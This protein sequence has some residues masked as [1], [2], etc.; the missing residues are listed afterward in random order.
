VSVL[1]FPDADTAKVPQMRPRALNST[2][3][4]I[5]YWSLQCD[6]IS[7]QSRVAA[8]AVRSQHAGVVLYWPN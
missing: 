3:F 7:R 5:N 1:G 4:P 8:S 6:P 2:P